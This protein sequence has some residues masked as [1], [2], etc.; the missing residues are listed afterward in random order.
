MPIWVNNGYDEFAKRMTSTCQL[1]LVELPMEKRGKNVSI[2]QIV[3]KEAD[4]ILSNVPKDCR[5]IALDVK[6]KHIDSQ[7]MADQFSE[8]LQSGQDI[9]FVIGGP[10]GLDPSCLSKANMI[11]S[12][13]H[14]TFPHQL[15]RIV[16]AE[17][18]YRA[19]SIYQNHP[20]HRK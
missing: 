3:K 6:G 8:W 12:L 7:T 16:L 1:R 2:N 13:S 4:K 15:V 14:L 10:D 19:W 17:Q 5:L 9:C 11:W 18:L 20:Y